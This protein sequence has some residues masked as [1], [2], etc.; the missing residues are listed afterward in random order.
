[1]ASPFLEVYIL[2]GHSLRRSIFD[3]YLPKG[4]IQIIS[5]IGSFRD[6]ACETKFIECKLNILVNL[7]SQIL[8]LLS[9]RTATLSVQCL[10]RWFEMISTEWRC[11]HVAR[12]I[13]TV[14]YIKYSLTLTD[15]QIPGTHQK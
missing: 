11:D 2:L 8:R 1:M 13:A 9:Y 12:Y 15:V 14:K 3:A 6:F 4:L 5:I 10:V 7:K